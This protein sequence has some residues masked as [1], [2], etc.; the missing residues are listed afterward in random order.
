M[1]VETSSL[2]TFASS[3]DKEVRAAS[4]AAPAIRNP[5]RQ[6]ITPR[7]FLTP[8]AFGIHPAREHAPTGPITGKP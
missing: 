2:S 8:Q 7:M 3:S 1:G 4:A 5:N 6:T